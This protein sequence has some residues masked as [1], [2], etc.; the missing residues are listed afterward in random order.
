MMRALILQELS[1]CLQKSIRTKRKALQGQES[2]SQSTSMTQE[3]LSDSYELCRISGAIVD[4]WRSANECLSLRTLESSFPKT[5]EQYRTGTLE[6][7]LPVHV[8]TSLSDVCLLADSII[9]EEK[10]DLL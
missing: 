5:F 8:Y 3:V 1:Q 6:I 7:S 9:S 4:S 2:S 10:G